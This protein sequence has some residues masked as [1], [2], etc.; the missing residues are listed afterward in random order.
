[1]IK[2]HAF[3]LDRI[4]FIE[5]IFYHYFP[6]FICTLFFCTHFCAE[7]IFAHG[8]ILIRIVHL[9]QIILVHPKLK[10][11]F[12]SSKLPIWS[13]LLLKVIANS[14]GKKG[15]YLIFQGAILKHHIFFGCTNNIFANYFT[16]VLQPFYPLLLIIQFLL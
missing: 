9:V 15:S 1:M 11:F 10:V 5:P 8:A 6:P 12:D 2:I 14:L 3:L 13:F 16:H 7:T 4:W